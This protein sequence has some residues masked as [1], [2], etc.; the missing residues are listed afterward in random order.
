MQSQETGKLS[1]SKGSFT[2]YVDDN[3]CFTPDF[4][5]TSSRVPVI[6][7]VSAFGRADPTVYS[8]GF[9]VSFRSRSHSLFA[10]HLEEQARQTIIH[11]HHETRH[12]YMNLQHYLSSPIHPYA[13][14]EIS[15]NYYHSLMAP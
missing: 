7:I 11:I 12:E 13:F 14:L 8:A 5:G 9:E 6:P 3:M 2:L 1:Q 10:S 4:P 15:A